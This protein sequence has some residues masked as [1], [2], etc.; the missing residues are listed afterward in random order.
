MSEAACMVEGVTKRYFDGD[1]KH[2]AV[3]DVSLAVEPGELVVVMGPS[4]SGKTT[5]LG[6]MGAM[7]A[8]TKGT[9]SI[10]GRDVTHLRDHHRSAWRREH[11]G[12]VFQDLG[13]LPG[14]SLLENVTLPLVPEGGPRREDRERAR[15]LLERVGMGDRVHTKVERLSGGER[16]RGAIARA[17]IAKPSLLLLDEPTAHVDAENAAAIVEIL[18]EQVA[19]GRA[20]VATTHDPRVAEEA[21][22]DRV[23]EMR[24]SRLT[25]EA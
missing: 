5:L 16:Q 6:L 15:A 10:G 11:V 12:F 17:L 2:V 21:R 4:G 23:L 24:A 13:L 8:P 1:R 22:V 20:V 25:S 3:D 14:M 7:I 19:E 18:A 9:V